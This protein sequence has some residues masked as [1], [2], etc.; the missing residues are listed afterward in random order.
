M[1]TLGEIQ[2]T[3]STVTTLYPESLAYEGMEEPEE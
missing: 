2:D 1:K 3:L